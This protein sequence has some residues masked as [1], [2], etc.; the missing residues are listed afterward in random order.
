MSR[1]FFIHGMGWALPKTELDDDFLHQEVGLERGPDWN[2]SRLGIHKRYTVLSKD[3]IRK[4]KN[5]DPMQAIPH[6]RANGETPLTLANAAARAALA[7]AQVKPEQVGMVIA[8]C[9]TPF[10]LLPTMASSVAKALGVGAGPHMD[11]N[12]ACSSFARHLKL[13]GDTSEKE[14]PEFVL[15]VQSSAY[16]TRTDYSSKSIDGYIW[17]DGAAAQVCSSR[18]GRL[19]V[20]PLVFATNP[21]GADEIAVDTAG[22]FH[23]DGAVVRE[24]SIRKTVEM[25]EQIAAA[26]KLYAEDVYTVSHQANYVMQNSILGHLHLPPERHL[27]NVHTQGNIAAAGAPSVI[28]QS[29]DR[30]KKGDQLVYAVLGAGLAW[31]GGY[32][33]VVS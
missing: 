7:Q 15:C 19:R 14:W 6:A 30:L 18:S 9:D 25:F 32:M 8:N 22:H 24:F 31:G 3:Y 20:E 21:K 29:W 10:D 1:P 27:R 28:A 2:S 17:G 13:L 12:S 16:T 26:K 33:E 23:Q 5:K 11:V 4:T